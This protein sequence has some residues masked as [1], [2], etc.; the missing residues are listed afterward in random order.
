MKII[1]RTQSGFILE[2]TSSEVEALAGGT[3]PKHAHWSGDA[4]NSVGMEFNVSECW[5]RIR[6]LHY[7]QDELRKVC[8]QLRAMADLLEPVSLVVETL[9]EK[10]ATS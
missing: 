4:G 6:N 3:L 8:G 7:K 1:A 2:A 10:E 5:Q 9:D